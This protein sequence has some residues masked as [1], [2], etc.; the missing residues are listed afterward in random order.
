MKS[1]IIWQTTDIRMKQFLII[2]LFL[3]SVSTVSADEPQKFSPE[4]F[5]ADLEQFIT[6]E[7][8]LTGDEAARFFPVYREMQQK[9]R[10][11]YK[12]KRELG[13]KKPA[14]EE[15]C[16]K[17]VEKSDELELQLNRLTQQY[18]CQFFKLLPASKVYDVIKAES[19]FH[20]QA[21]RKW[22]EH[23]QQQPPKK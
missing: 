9:Q 17:A 7:A 19:R 20:R 16:R 2:I 5:Q 13:M 8:G 21:I 23:R 18:H 1:T 3:L 14:D 4:K 10:A 15:S 22:N 6:K 11:I 12:Q